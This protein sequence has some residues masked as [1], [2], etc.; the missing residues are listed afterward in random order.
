MP[1]QDVP[2]NKLA[3]TARSGTQVVVPLPLAR[4]RLRAQ[5]AVPRAG[6]RPHWVQPG[7]RKPALPWLADHVGVA[8]ST[9]YPRATAGQESRIGGLPEANHDQQQ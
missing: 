5:K 7:D 3:I 6:L 1:L 8:R 9:G 4:S 2:V